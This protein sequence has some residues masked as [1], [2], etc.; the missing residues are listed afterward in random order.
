MHLR[1]P[2]RMARQPCRGLHRRH[3]HEVAYALCSLQGAP[4]ERAEPLWGQGD[5]FIRA[6]CWFGWLQ[7]FEIGVTASSGFSSPKDAGVPSRRQRLPSLT[8]SFPVFAPLPVFALLDDRIR[9]WLSAANSAVLAVH[10][11]ELL[12]FSSYFLVSSPQAT[13]T[14]SGLLD[15][16]L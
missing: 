1:Q 3:K 6:R 2:P 10:S 9:S 13:F 11:G 7:E 14:V 5:N 16:A 12:S 4:G 15:L 8:D